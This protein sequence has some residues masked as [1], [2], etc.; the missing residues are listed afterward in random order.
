VQ[1]EGENSGRTGGS[2]TPELARF[3]AELFAG[4]A[5]PAT[6]T[7]SDLRHTLLGSDLFM[8]GDS[9]I[10]YKLDRTSLLVEVDELI[11]QH[12]ADTSLER[13]LVS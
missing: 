7:L 11:D 5:L 4:S 12:G 6:A 3:I 13:L 8:S 9:E 2:A 1:K 10:M